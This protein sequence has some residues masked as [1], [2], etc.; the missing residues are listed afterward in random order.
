M[1][2]LQR[3]L[4]MLTAVGVFCLVAQLLS[5]SVVSVNAQTEVPFTF[6]DVFEMP[7]QNGAIRFAANG[8]YESAN[9]ED[10]VWTFRN[11]YIA[12]SRSVEK[13][14]LTISATDCEVTFF[15]YLTAPYSY[16]VA[17]LKWVILPYTVSGHGSQVINLGFDPDNGQLD[18]IL[19]GNFAARNQGWSKT[20]DGTLTITGSYSNVTLWYIAHPEPSEDDSFLSEH[21]VVIGSA[22]FL[23]VTVVLATAINYRKKEGGSPLN[24]TNVNS[25]PEEAA[26]GQ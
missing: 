6:E 13:L 14:N 17:L 21:Y 10:G 1:K 7:L 25:N 23:A 12:A 26:G 16:G 24:K 3:R 2:E 8:T 20:D 18:V 22:G 4:S 15:P 5:C 9:L 19:D 11:L